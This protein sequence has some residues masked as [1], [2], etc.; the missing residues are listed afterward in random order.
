MSDDSQPAADLQQEPGPTIGRAGRATW[1]ASA[2]EGS[3]FADS[4]PGS[5]PP[6][7]PVRRG[8]RLITA[9]LA[10]VLVVVAGVVVVAYL[11]SPPSA[12]PTVVEFEVLPG[13]GG[14]RVAAE[15][16]DAGLVRS[17]R[18]FGA[19]LRFRDLDHSIGEGLYDLTP[20]MSSADIAARLVEGG[21]PRVVN[22]AIPEGWR[23]A[24]V[25]DRLAAN[26]VSTRDDLAAVISDPVALTIPFLPPD[27][28]L[29][30]FLFPAV[31]EVP[32]KAAADAALALMVQRFRMEL[33]D[34]DPAER[35]QE[36]GLS[37]YGWVTLASM[38][39]AEAASDEEMPII[40]GVFANRLELGMLLQSDPTVAYG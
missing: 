39:Q 20:A 21:R 16:A 34:I 9:L 1:S 18:V 15:L 8:S 5:P 38:V 3:A 13:W 35:L 17:A 31:Y 19:Y 26:G 24:N 14:S 40:A 10:I 32:I 11:L 27:R 28:P 30:G 6:P 37:V 25:V 33:D 2:T 12:T 23:A 29:E 4:T 22:I 36:L 7:R